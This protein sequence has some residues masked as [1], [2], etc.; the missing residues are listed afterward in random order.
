MTRS[1]P[2]TVL[3]VPVACCAIE[4]LAAESALAELGVNLVIDTPESADVLVVSGTVTHTMAPTIRAL[5]D[6]MPAGRRVVA[7]GVCAT[8]GGPYWDSYSVL[9]GIDR[10]IPVDRYVPG[11]PPR[12]HALVEAIT[13]LATDVLVPAELG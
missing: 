13:S 11:C 6:R 4:A 10:I 5:Y 1:A 7:F 3:H 12:P 9:Q 8:T 2:L